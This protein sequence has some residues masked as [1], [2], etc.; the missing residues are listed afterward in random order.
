[1]QYTL[2][3]I[4]WGL[5]CAGYCIVHHA[6]TAAMIPEP[7]PL[8][9]QH[10]SS[11]HRFGSLAS[12]AHYQSARKCGSRRR[13][14]C[15]TTSH[16]LGSAEHPLLPAWRRK[17]GVG[18]RRRKDVN[19]QHL[20]AEYK[21]NAKPFKVLYT[22]LLCRLGIIQSALM[23]VAVIQRSQSADSFPMPISLTCTRTYFILQ[24]R[25]TDN[26]AM[27]LGPQQKALKLAVPL[28]VRMRLL[29]RSESNSTLCLAHTKI[30]RRFRCLLAAATCA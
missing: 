4:I 11:T 5:Q 10:A 19:Q 15:K 2:H 12:R 7:C 16:V 20:G 17:Q 13:S 14:I 26:P 28:P 25:C 21:Q 8:S 23:A 18:R 24:H 9:C 1:M 29:W 22:C 6:C 30:Q 3:Q 27:A